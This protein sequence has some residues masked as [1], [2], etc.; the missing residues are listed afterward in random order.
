MKDNYNIKHNPPPLS[1]EDIGKHKDFDALLEKFNQ[2][3]GYEDADIPTG[4]GSSQFL[5]KYIIGGG[6]ALITAVALFYVFSQN[7]DNS[8][9]QAFLEPPL[10]L[11]VPFE[12]VTVHA[13]EGDTLK[14]TSG[15][16]LIVPPNALRT[17]DGSP[18]KGE[19][20]L[21]YRELT[22]AQAQLLAGIA[23][24]LNPEG[25][26]QAASI[27]ELRGTADGKDLSIDPQK[28]LEFIQNLEEDWP[29]IAARRYHNNAW[30]V[31]TQ[32]KVEA[33]ELSEKQSE[34]SMIKKL[35][36]LENNTPKPSMPL[37]PKAIGDDMQ[38][39]DM[40]IKASEFPELVHY[41]KIIWVAPKKDLKAE[42]FEVEWDNMSVER[43]ADLEYEFVFEKGTERITVG[44]LPQVPYSQNAMK[45]YEKAL[46]T[47]NKA[48][49]VRKQKIEEEMQAW[50]L[51]ENGAFQMEANQKSNYQLLIEEF[52][53]WTFGQMATPNDLA[54]EQLS[55]ESE[56]ETVITPK[57]IFVANKEKHIFYSLGPKAPY[58]ID[59]DQSQIWVIDAKGQ[60]WE[61]TKASKNKIYMSKSSAEQLLNQIKGDIQ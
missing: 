38:P 22:A 31:S 53:L 36:E 15:S 23:Q 16:L 2:D 44:A 51:R 46:E 32:L 49:E 1:S 59:V 26:L 35:A 61:M 57:Q 30:S 45:A 10:E 40:D 41:A 47:Y 13:E 4:G 3:G 55:F 7:Q 43:K 34:E 60:L 48:M 20:V 58:A 21:A 37:K 6:L 18:L 50:M 28:P 29:A 9:T 27:F 5:V 52:G 25:H 39:F 14:F 8:S 54:K 19:A 11:D 56:E 17:E 42:W 24:Q 33:P 12:E